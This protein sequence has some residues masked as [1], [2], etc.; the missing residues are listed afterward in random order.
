MFF[1]R[2]LYEAGHD[3]GKGKPAKGLGFRAFF[4]PAQVRVL[5]LQA[6]RFQILRYLW[7]LKHSAPKKALRFF[8]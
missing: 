4:N 2:S 8:L 1:L 6:L 3:S 7:L 5:R